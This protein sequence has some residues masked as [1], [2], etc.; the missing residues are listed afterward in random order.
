M[1]SWV[2]NQKLK[3]KVTIKYNPFFGYAMVF[4]SFL[5]KLTINFS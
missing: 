4:D 5:T 3:I 2:K 1:K